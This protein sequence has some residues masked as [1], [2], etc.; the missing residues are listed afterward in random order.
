[1]YT[2]AVTRSATI[3]GRNSLG[4]N[5]FTTATIRYYK[6]KLHYDADSDCRSWRESENSTRMIGS[7]WTM[8]RFKGVA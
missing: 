1:M 3:S 2:P 8:N 7:E 4:K 5:Y 6:C